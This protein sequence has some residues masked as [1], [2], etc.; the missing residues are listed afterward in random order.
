MIGRELRTIGFGDQPSAGDADQR[1]VRF[2]VVRGR[3]QRLVGRH[4]R[5]TLG[6]G[7]VD[8][9]AFGA[10]LDLKAVPLQF[11]IEAIA[12]Q[13]RQPVAARRRNGRLIAADRHGNRPRRPAGQRNQPVGLA[14]EPAKL[15]MRRLMGRRLEEGAR[16]EPHQAAVPLLPR[17]QQDEARRLGQDGPRARFHVDEIHRQRTADDRLDAVARDL[18]G[19]LQ[20]PEHVVAVGQR[21]RRLV[22]LL[23]ELG[24]LAD[25]DRAMQQRIGRADVEMDKTGVGHWPS[26]IQGCGALA[27]TSAT[28]RAA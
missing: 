22:V 28:D 7:E 15:D 25:G 23:G 24:K 5:Q 20:R 12:E 13:L 17:G 16:V 27:P 2:V 21:Q 6:E 18:F 26:R 1:I 19:K 11:D 9:P 8:Q 3:K 14:F 10:P 4:Q